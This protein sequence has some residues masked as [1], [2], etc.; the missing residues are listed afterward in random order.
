MKTDKRVERNT[1]SIIALRDYLREIIQ[2]PNSFCEN[3]TLLESL[4][5]QGALSKLNDEPR[6]IFVSS[7]NTVKRIA[8]RALEGGFDALDRLRIGAQDAIAAE[9]AKGHRSNK[10]NKIGLCKR[11]K[12]LELEN[13]Q[14]RQD[15]LRLTLAFEKSLAHGRDYAREPNKSTALALC[16]RQQRELRDGLSL[17][18][19]PL[20]V[21]VASINN[22]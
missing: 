7:L 16:E 2:N 12:E 22:A 8:E 10:I 6:G 19:H 9:K 1:Q 15:L 5:S 11:V 21:N 14:L 3:T 20:P 18:Q 13:Q 17:R 4:K